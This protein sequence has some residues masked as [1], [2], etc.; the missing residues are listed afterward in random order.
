MNCLWMHYSGR[1]L[2]HPVLSTAFPCRPWKE[3]KKHKNTKTS[4]WVE[5]NVLDWAGQ[6]NSLETEYS[7]LD[8]VLLLQFIRN[9]WLYFLRFDHRKNIESTHAQGWSH[10]WLCYNLTFMSFNSLSL[11]LT[12]IWVGNRVLCDS[13]EIL[14]LRDQ[15]DSVF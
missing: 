2:G 8:C 13:E 14:M 5:E 15:K 1:F 10:C 11:E 6:I 12:R 7:V 3:R 4:F 9:T